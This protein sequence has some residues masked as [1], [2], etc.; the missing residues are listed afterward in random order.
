M[1]NF[2]QLIK[3]ILSNKV[4]EQRPP[5]LIDIGASGEI[6]EKWILIAEKSICIAFDADDRDFT[7]DSAE[8]DTGYRKLYKFNRI[9]LS[10]AQKECTFYLTKSP[11]CSSTLKPDKKNLADWMFA[12]LFEVE[13]EAKLP[14]T[15]VEECL[16][17]LKL[18]YIDWYK[19]DSQGIDMDI[20]LSIPE[21]IRDN[22]LA[23]DFEP[24]LMDAYLNE[25]KMGGLLTMLDNESYWISSFDVKGTQ[26]LD[27]KY[28][29]LSGQL[30]E[31]PCWA[32]VT[33]LKNVD[34]SYNLRSALLLMVF[35]LV[36]NQWGYALQI[37]ETMS[38][39]DPIF[40]K[41]HAEILNVVKRN[42]RKQSKKLYPLL[43]KFVK[44][45]IG[46]K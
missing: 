40:D 19:V 42:E 18:D 4:F 2:E 9:V 3:S 27:Q 43:K 34:V 10:S 39:I 12:P 37:C 33:S 20:F 24:G 17:N 44:K 5:V 22:I 35:S 15:T 25:N 30:H 14:C 36:E 7:F 38:A 1:N 41:L 21:G 45:A 8:G 16:T 29:S 26:R 28:S 32:G 11:Y 13:R 46:R 6:F 23:A 31:S